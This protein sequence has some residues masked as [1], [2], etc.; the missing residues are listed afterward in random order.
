[1]C[2]DYMLLNETKWT[3]LN[4]NDEVQS[5]ILWDGVSSWAPPE[6]CTVRL[7]EA[8]DEASLAVLE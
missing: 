1:M 5:I 3:I 2:G 4:E 8:S 6:G 7:T